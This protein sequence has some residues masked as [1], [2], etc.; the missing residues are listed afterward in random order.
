MTLLHNNNYQLHRAKYSLLYPMLQHALIPIVPSPTSPAAGAAAAASP[1]GASSSASASSSSAAA[2]A[3][4]S[5]SLPSASASAAASS[6]SSSSSSSYFSSSAPYSLPA[7]AVLPPVS[8][9]YPPPQLPPKHVIARAFAALPRTETTLLP[10]YEIPMPHAGSAAAAA[11]AAA[12]AGAAPTDLSAAAAPTAD[13]PMSAAASVDP[14]TSTPATTHTTTAP[15]TAPSPSAGDATTSDVVMGAAAPSASASSSSSSSSAAAEMGAAGAGAG[16]AQP[17]PMLAIES[18]VQIALPPLNEAHWG[19]RE[20]LSQTHNYLLQYERERDREEALIQTVVQAF[21]L[22]AINFEYAQ[23]VPPPPLP[24][25]LCCAVLC[26]ALCFDVAL[27]ILDFLFLCLVA[28]VPCRV[29]DLKLRIHNAIE[30]L[31]SNKPELMSPSASA[32]PIATGSS[33][34]YKTIDVLKL[35]ALLGKFTQHVS[36]G[37]CV[38]SRASLFFRLLTITFMWLC[39]CVQ[40]YVEPLLS[41][42]QEKLLSQSMT[43]DQRAFQRAN[44]AQTTSVAVSSASLSATYAAAQAQAAAAN[45]TNSTASSAA[46]ST[47]SSAAKLMSPSPTPRLIPSTERVFIS[48]DRKWQ[49]K[50]PEGT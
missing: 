1:S 33:G 5:E 12:A 21:S 34:R 10:A 30:S 6:S 46:P 25:L 29:E 36:A 28:A 23:Y 18:H 43:A 17:Q 32:A 48:S 45:G 8:T 49:G 2:A 27:L 38:P 42:S 11:A 50:N 15:T 47:P 7:T 31:K 35:R 37:A 40:E 3:S 9:S 19:I 14:T 24:V 39:G 44:P 41:R 4:T 16:S 26:A 13:A 20:R 22:Q